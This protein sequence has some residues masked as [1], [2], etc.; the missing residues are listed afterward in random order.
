M[1][2][3]LDQPSRRGSYDAV[4]HRRRELVV[5]AGQ[6][7]QQNELRPL[8]LLRLPQHAV[9]VTH[10]LLHVARLGQLEAAQTEGL[11]RVQQV[12][13]VDHHRALNAILHQ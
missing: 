3:N 9:D 4:H 13:E 11:V 1:C 10:G 5:H 2:G 12:V 7:G 8:H 6:I